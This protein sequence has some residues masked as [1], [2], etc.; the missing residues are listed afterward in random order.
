MNPS[1]LHMLPLLLCDAKLFLPPQRAARSPSLS[2]LLILSLHHRPSTA[3]SWRNHKVQLDQICI[4]RTNIQTTQSTGINFIIISCHHKC[5]SLKLKRALH[6]PKCPWKAPSLDL[7][8]AVLAFLVL[9]KSLAITE[10]RSG[11][12]LLR[13]PVF[14]R[15]VPR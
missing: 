12:L 9:V 4:F 8:E 1:S 3:L 7:T 6:M 14:W 13:K 10:C 2:I 15:Q 5:M 11:C